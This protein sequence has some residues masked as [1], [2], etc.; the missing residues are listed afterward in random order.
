MPPESTDCLQG[1]RWATL[2]DPMDEPASLVDI[3]REGVGEAAGQGGWQA[4]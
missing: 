2:K 1:S 4:G 3:S